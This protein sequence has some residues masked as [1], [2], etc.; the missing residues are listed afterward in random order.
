MTVQAFKNALAGGGARPNQFRVRGTFPSG[1][2][3]TLGTVLGAVGG[4]VGGDVGNLLGAANNL[5]GGGGPSRKVEFLC[6]AASL[7]NF[8]LGTIEVPYRGRT[9]KF[10]GDRTFQSWSITIVNDTDFAIRNAFEQWSDLINS[11]VQNVGPSGL[12]QVSQRWEVDQLDRTGSVLKTYSFEDCWPSEISS[13]DLSFDSNDQIEE[14]TVEL[15]FNFF[16]TNTT[17]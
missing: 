4:A 7:P 3:G 11:H 14:F 17:T 9:I 13:I 10:P 1:A 6:K 15:Q 12:L 5:I 2:T 16:T 8:S